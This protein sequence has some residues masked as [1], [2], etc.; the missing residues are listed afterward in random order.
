MQTL[1]TF[2]VSAAPPGS[3]L[4]SGTLCDTKNIMASRM[5]REVLQCR[6]Q[7]GVGGGGQCRWIKHVV[8]QLL[9][10]QQLACIN[11]CWL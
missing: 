8:T 10:W 5:L 2:F 7:V 9:W 4:F 6:M 3:G 1:L 11:P